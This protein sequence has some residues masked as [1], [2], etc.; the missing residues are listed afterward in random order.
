MHI[1][2]TYA[3]Y[4]NSHFTLHRLSGYSRSHHLQSS[5]ASFGYPS[6][7]NAR[8][9][10]V[11]SLALRNASSF[12]SGGADKSWW[13]RHQVT[14]TSILEFCSFDFLI[15]LYL[16]VFADPLHPIHPTPGRSSS[17]RLKRYPYSISASPLATDYRNS[18]RNMSESADSPS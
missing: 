9:D 13:G 4:V 15:A 8:R 12:T 10:A 2:C 7:R 16:D 14:S 18:S 11:V 5:A 17:K 6:S 1:T 3:G